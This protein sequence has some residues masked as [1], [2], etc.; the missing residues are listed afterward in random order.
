M[1]KTFRPGTSVTVEI[2]FISEQGDKVIPVSAKLRVIDH[3]DVLVV[4]RDV[5]ELS[6]G[7]ATITLGAELNS[8]AFGETSGVRLFTL[9]MFDGVRTALTHHYYYLK[10]ELFL[11]VGS[12]TVVSFAKALSYFPSMVNI[13]WNGNRPQLEAALVEAYERLAA[14]PLQR[15]HFPKAS[16]SAMTA[17]DWA[18]VKSHVREA[19]E[20]AQIAEAFD[21][22]N[23]DPNRALREQRIF[24]RSVGESTTTFFSEK[25]VN[26][27]VSTRAWRYISRYVDTRV[28]ITR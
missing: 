26:H 2:P 11:E 15:N 28:V 17:E 7:S 21:L 24:S 25:A 12:N 16:I 3:N 22:I 1:V 27:G 5:T 14:F 4:E 23:E 19:F 10:K 8:L 9:E 6:G 13:S 20:K 18:G